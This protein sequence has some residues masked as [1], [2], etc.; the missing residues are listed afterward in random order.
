MPIK[1][2]QTRIRR[3]IFFSHRE[4]HTAQEDPK[5][6]KG[7]D[8]GVNDKSEQIDCSKECIRNSER[9]LC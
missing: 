5:R 7:P 4:Q 9:L 3:P 1:T 6:A 2:Q 8:Q